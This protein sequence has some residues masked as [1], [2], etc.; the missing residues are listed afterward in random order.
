MTEA[1]QN[2]SFEDLTDEELVALCHAKNRQALDFLLEKY[3]PLVRAKSMSYFLIGAD[4]EDIIQEGMIGL[5]KAVR[6]FRMERGAS[7][8]S[9]AEVCVTRQMISAVKSATR[10]KHTPLNNYVSLNKPLFENEQDVTLLDMIEQDTVLS[11]EALL[12]QKEQFSAISLKMGELLSKLECRVLN[13]YLQGKS[14][15][16]IGA[17][18]HRTPKSIDN[19]LQRIKRKL[20]KLSDTLD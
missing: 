14:Y 6:D 12:I 5:F 16:E 17:L 3:C 8:R 11:P 4:R 9:F 19:A 7:F 15:T 20:E 18:L 1:V 13:Y 10:Q 2:S